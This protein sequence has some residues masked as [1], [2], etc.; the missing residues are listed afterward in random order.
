MTGA[1]WKKS[2]LRHRFN[3]MISWRGAAVL[4]VAFGVLWCPWFGLQA[5][6][7]AERSLHAVFSGRS[8]PIFN[9]A[10]DGAPSRSGIQ[11]SEESTAAAGRRSVYRGPTTARRIGY[12]VSG[13]LLLGIFTWAYARFR[14]LRRINLQLQG[15]NA[16]N[17]AVL[18]AAMEGIMTIDPQGVV[19]TVNEAAKRIFARTEDELVGHGVDTLMPK[20]EAAEF[21]RR[22]QVYQ[23][24]GSERQK[25]LTDQAAWEAMGLRRNGE[26]F[27]IRLGVAPV[28]VANKALFVCTIHDMTDQRKAERQME[29][30][31][32]HDLLTGLLNQR[33]V[34]LL[35][36]NLVHHARRHNHEFTCLNLG[37]ARLT[38]INDVYG[39]QAGDAVLVEVAAFLRQNIRRSD[40]L[41]RAQETLLARAGGDRFLLVLPKT[42]LP[43]ARIFAERVLDALDEVR[44]DI[45]DERMHIDAKLG[46]AGFPEHGDTPAELLTRAETALFQA[47]GKSTSAIHIFSSA[48]RDQQL[49]VERWLGALRAALAERRFVLHFQPIMHLKTGRVEHYEALLRMEA[50]DGTLVLPGEFIQVAE[51]FGLIAR[52]DYRVLELAFSYLAGMAETA[53]EVS[54]SVNLSGAHIGD[55]S[56]FQWLERIFQEQGVSPEQLIF[57]ITETTAVHDLLR[58]KT[59]MESLKA[60]GCRFALDDFGV[61]FSSFAHLQALPVD[62]VKIDGSFVQNLHANPQDQALVKALTSVA[63]SFGKEVVAEFV[64]N[65]A[66]LALLGEFGVDYAQGYYI[67]RPQPELD[68]GTTQKVLVQG[69]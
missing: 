54:L 34:V 10:E 27:P 45:G 12:L 20:S 8:P 9:V 32:D 18:N 66:A 26:V 60:L 43:G 35:M 39:R 1:Q 48:D 41:A 4:A 59:F 56:L 7:P 29:Y 37:I 28:T 23:A 58:A 52:I 42:G 67:G 64:E 61:G 25:S 24:G 69:A 40:I 50:R 3:G 14:A 31:A 5:A 65:E 46:I 53:P 57:E 22:L 13:L 47:K 17:A 36:E 2:R 55:D 44:V 68:T 19:H 62:I 38:H 15:A 6:P 33:G 30:L 21:V 11:R 49:K 63:H 51:R 16:F